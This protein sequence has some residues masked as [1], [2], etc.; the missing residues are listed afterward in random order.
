MEQIRGEPATRARLEIR[1]RS[2]NGEGG[3]RFKPGGLKVE[4]NRELCWL[5]HLGI[6]G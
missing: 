3:M 1:F 6:P 4:P 5:G 2:P